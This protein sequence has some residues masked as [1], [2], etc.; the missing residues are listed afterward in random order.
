[1]IAPAAALP[2]KHLIYE[3][4]FTV[5]GKWRRLETIAVK[6]ALQPHALL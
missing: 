3:H 6:V 2:L 5:R 4:N 1:V